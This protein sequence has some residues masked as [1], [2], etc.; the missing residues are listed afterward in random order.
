[1]DRPVP[2]LC[3][4][5][6]HFGGKP[7]NHFIEQALQSA[8]FNTHS[9]DPTQSYNDEIREREFREISRRMQDEIQAGLSWAQEILGVEH[10]RAAPPNRLLI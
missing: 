6:K 7:D 10:T 8:E 4:I 3:A 5:L 2:T 1:L 9:K